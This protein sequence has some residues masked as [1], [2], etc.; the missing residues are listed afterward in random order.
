MERKNYYLSDRQL[1]NLGIEAS[2]LGISV[3]EVLRRIIDVHYQEHPASYMNT[4]M[5]LFSG[6]S[7]FSGIST[8]LVLG[9]QIKNI[10]E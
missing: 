9:Q 1:L 3:S 5:A 2:G 4:S 6:I 8:T 10:G 7:H